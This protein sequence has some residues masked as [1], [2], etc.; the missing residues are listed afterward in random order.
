MQRIWDLSAQASPVISQS[1]QNV[2]DELPASPVPIPK[3]GHSKNL[4]A[5]V[6]AICLFVLPLSGYI[7]WL[8]NAVPN[9]YH[10]YTAEESPREITL[11]DGSQVYLN[12]HTRITYANYRDQ[13]RVTFSEGEAFFEVFSDK[14]HPFIV[15]TGTGTITVTGTQ[16]NVWKHNDDVA[17][18]LTEGSI[19]VN[20]DLSEHHLTPGLQA[21]FG[22]TQPHIKVSPANIEQTASW[23]K[24]LLILD[25]QPLSEVAP[26]I[27]RY[28]Q[29]PLVL[30]SYSVGEMR[31][32]GTY[33]TDNMDSMVD[34]LPMILP[35]KLTRHEDGS[36]ELSE[37]KK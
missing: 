3:T 30:T 35:V 13:R 22:S 2:A 37:Q 1:I 5:R 10:R 17:V 16:F 20:T 34:T 9:S 33:H 28:L 25:N 26:I 36:L 15:D 4:F 7:G 23:K 24:G 8:M 6:L 19:R 21:R 11:P 18:T 12:L 32:G 27:S 29:K 31:I 14:N